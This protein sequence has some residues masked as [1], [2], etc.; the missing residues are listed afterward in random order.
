MKERNLIELV[1]LL[2]V[3][4]EK[5]MPGSEQR[6]KIQNLVFKEIASLNVSILRSMYDIGYDKS[7]CEPKDGDGGNIIIAG[8]VQENW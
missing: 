5:V 3:A 4:R 2:L 1:A 7:L 8:N 6:L